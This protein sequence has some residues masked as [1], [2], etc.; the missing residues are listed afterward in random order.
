MW[1]YE[2]EKGTYLCRPLVARV[3]PINLPPVFPNLGRNASS[4]LDAREVLAKRADHSLT[5]AVH[6]RDIPLHLLG[7]NRR[8]QRG[9]TKPCL[10][11]CQSLRLAQR[12][13]FR[14]GSPSQ[15]TVGRLERPICV[16]RLS[17]QLFVQRNT[18]GRSVRWRR[19]DR[20][21]HLGAVL[22]RNKIVPSLSVT[23]FSLLAT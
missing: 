1:L 10:V 15:V 3:A 23:T 11:H 19:M 17:G 7:G 6:R 18:L 14:V 12:G 9:F 16:P 5:R 21:A 2:W 13:E 20:G 22:V 8:S 4:A